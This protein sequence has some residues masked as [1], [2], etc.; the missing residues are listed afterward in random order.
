MSCVVISQPMLFPWVGLLEQIRLADTYVHYDDVQF[1]KGG[2]INRVEVKTRQGP[3]WLTIPLS[4]ASFGR[5]IREV[6]AAVEVDWRRRHLATLSQE[7]ARAP[8]LRDML[9]LV[10]RV[11]AVDTGRLVDILV[12]SIRELSEYLDLPAG[13]DAPFSSALGIPGRSSA[14]VLAVVRRFGGTRYVTGH[15]ARAYLNHEAFEAAGVSV[16]YLDY[17]ELP[18]PQLHGAFTPF[19]SGL[20]LVAN[21]GRAGRSVI[22][23]G[24]VPWRAFL[25]R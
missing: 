15:G 12:A 18:Y 4:G 7:Y 16:E 14:R 25:K 24:S 21:A 17:Q 8:H 2:F 19:V 1:E 20:D 10:E 23:S 3:R 11:Y 22:C 6:R 9:A 13:R 5:E